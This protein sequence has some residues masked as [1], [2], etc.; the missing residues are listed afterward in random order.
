MLT[1]SKYAL[2]T[3]AQVC[4]M[5]F[6]SIVERISDDAPPRQTYLEGQCAVSLCPYGWSMLRQAF[7]VLLQ[8]SI[9]VQN[10]CFMSILSNSECF[11]GTPA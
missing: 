3:Q 1:F 5:F 4:F 7:Y 10:V 2:T 9:A 6:G 8:Q 11:M